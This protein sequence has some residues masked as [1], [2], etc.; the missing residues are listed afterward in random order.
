MA[1]ST[2]DSDVMP[3]ISLNLVHRFRL[4]HMFDAASLRLLRHQ[5]SCWWIQ[6]ED[7]AL[8]LLVSVFCI[9]KQGS[10]SDVELEMRLLLISSVISDSRAGSH[11]NRHA[12]V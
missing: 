8:S 9:I 1:V 10:G 11:G 5:S 12:F 6:V 4:A 7:L 2:S 3:A